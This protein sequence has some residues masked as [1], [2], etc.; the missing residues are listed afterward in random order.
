MFKTL[1]QVR[2]SDHQP[3]LLKIKSEP[4]NCSSMSCAA[5]SGRGALDSDLYAPPLTSNEQVFEQLVSKLSELGI[6][7]TS[8]GQKLTDS[9]AAH[10][11]GRTN[12]DEKEGCACACSVGELGCDMDEINLAACQIEYEKTAFS[13]ACAPDI[14]KVYMPLMEGWVHH[15]SHL[16]IVGVTF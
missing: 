5:C 7:H 13:A 8:V 1:Q 4:L 2:G 10:V 11:S 14:N 6:A 9:L 3:I 15:T 16:E 12:P